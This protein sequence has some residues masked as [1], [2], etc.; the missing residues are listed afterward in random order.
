MTRI[1]AGFAGSRELA[2]PKAGTRPTSDR[3][4]EAVFSA[5]DARDAIVDARVLDLFAGSG[6]LGLESL[7]RGAASVVLVEKNAKAAETARKN[8][9]LI[10]AIGKLPPACAQVVVNS[11]AQF[12]D[13]LSESSADTGSFD[14]VFIDPPYDVADDKLDDVLDAL[15]PHLSPGAEVVVERSTRSAHPTPPGGLT[16]T[17]SKAYGETTIHWLICDY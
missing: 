13:G 8:A 3:V 17:K 16:L 2:V 9:E 15:T 14:L 12:L 1:I 7:S 10:R 4:R 11:V 5:L 6:A